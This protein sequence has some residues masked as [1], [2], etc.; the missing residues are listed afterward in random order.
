MA[1]ACTFGPHVTDIPEFTTVPFSKKNLY[2]RTD[3]VASN[4][5]ACK[6]PGFSMA[7]GNFLF[8]FVFQKKRPNVQIKTA[9]PNPVA[10][11]SQI[12]NIRP[13]WMFFFFLKQESMLTWIDGL[14][15]QEHGN[16]GRYTVYS[17]T[18]S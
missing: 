18:L 16:T 14:S 17:A 13:I 15:Y 9:A 5:R 2:F 4:D 1:I 6:L 7:P 11:P 8:S 3:V 12:W 10:L